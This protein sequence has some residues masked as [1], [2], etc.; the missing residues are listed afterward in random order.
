MYEYVLFFIVAVLAGL[1]WT[2]SGY[3]NNWRK[4]HNNENWE[5]FNLKSM[6]ND[7]I[8]GSVLGVAVVLIQPISVAIGSPYEI[9]I[10]TDFPSFV[11]GIFGMYPIVGLVDK[12][13]VGFVAGK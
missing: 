1:T 10:I 3:L 6:R 11:M 7:A 4:N 2:M 9:P 13:V 12:F 5:G 8:L